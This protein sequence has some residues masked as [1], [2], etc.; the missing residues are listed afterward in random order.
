MQSFCEIK[1]EDYP[2]LSCDLLY[3]FYLGI[4]PFTKMVIDLNFFISMIS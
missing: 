4:P 3:V 1:W 2:S